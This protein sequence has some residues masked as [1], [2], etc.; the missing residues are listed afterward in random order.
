MGWQTFQPFAKALIGNLASGQF[1]WGHF[2]ACIDHLSPDAKVRIGADRGSR[3]IVT[4]ED[5]FHEL[6]IDKVDNDEMDCEGGEVGAIFPT[7]D[8]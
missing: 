7:S 5:L 3:N 6:E 2:P 8:E 4:I 1:I